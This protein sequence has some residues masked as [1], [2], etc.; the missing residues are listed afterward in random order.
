MHERL[1]LLAALDRYADRGSFPRN[2]VVPY[3]NPVFIDPYGTAC[4]VGQ[5]II[6]SGHRDLAERI[7]ASMNLA[8][9]L[10]M[11]S[12]PLW[13]EIAAWAQQHGFAAEE[14]AWIQ[15]AYPPNLPWAPLGG[16]TDGPVT[17]MKALANGDLLVGGL[18]TN[19]GGVA[20][21]NV[22]IWN[23]S[24]Y[25]PLGTGL[26][27]DVTSAVEFNGALYVGGAMLNGMSDLAKWDGNSWS[28]STLFDGKY[29]Y[30]SALHVHD[31]MLYAAGYMS[32]FAGNTNFVQVWTG[33]EWMPVGSAFNGPVFALGSY[34]GALV[35]GGDF[36]SLVTSPVPPT[37]LHVAAMGDADW[38]QLGDGLDAPVRT[39]LEVDGTLHAGGDVYINVVPTFG[40]ARISG[41]SSYWEPLL[42]DHVNYMPSDV[43]PNYISSLAARNGEIYFGGRFII[44]YM[45]G[46]SGNNLGRFNGTANDVTPLIAV[47]A[48]VNTVAIIDQGLYTGGEFYLTYPYAATLDLTT[49][50]VD[51]TAD[52]TVELSPN[53]VHDQL[54]IRVPAQVSSTIPVIFDAA[55]RRLE[56]A[57]ER[58][59]DGYLT[60][61]SALPA[62][63][64][65]VRMTTTAGTVQARFVKE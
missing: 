59:D 38:M 25:V 29:P 3:R 52:M 43:G 14:L 30:V 35:A 5:L 36:T 54:R 47:D 56:L 7:S 53:P 57:F 24:S 17:V 45:V 65:V 27:G 61:V 33:S 21:N 9:V 34:N 41:S 40:L 51:A 63:A 1:D 13:P 15:P 49:T 32:G 10:D 62:G 28:F 58:K 2:E 11:P 37:I 16:G 20:A 6:E 23:G 48:Q 50:V 22:A 26:Q 19:A 8:Y 18:F 12:S 55:G 44:S 42:P 46:T 60:S 31:G 64:Y 4:A 39:L